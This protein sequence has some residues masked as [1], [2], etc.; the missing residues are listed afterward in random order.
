MDARK[1]REEHGGILVVRVEYLGFTR[2]WI[3]SLRLKRRERFG[4]P[5]RGTRLGDSWYSDD[6]EQ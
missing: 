6:E 4:V 1:E 2:I 5:E 3:G